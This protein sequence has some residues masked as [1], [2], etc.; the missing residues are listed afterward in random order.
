MCIAC[1][2]NQPLCKVEPG[3]A[4]SACILPVGHSERDHQNSSGF[5]WFL[6]PFQRT[7]ALGWLE[8][9]GYVFASASPTDYQIENVVERFYDGGFSAFLEATATVS[10]F[11]Y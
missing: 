5:K 4:R 2:H 7:E 1:E 6:T 10:L 11:K 8:D 9:V 3:G